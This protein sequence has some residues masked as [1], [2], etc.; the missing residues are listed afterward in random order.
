MS[1]LAMLMLPKIQFYNHKSSPSHVPPRDVDVA[2]NT[3]LC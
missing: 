1:P 3:V 2:E